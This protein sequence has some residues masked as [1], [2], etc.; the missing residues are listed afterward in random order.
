VQT[1]LLGLA[2]AI[3]VALVTTLVAPLFVDWNRYRVAFED[4]ASRLT[5]VTVRVNGAIDARILPTP[6]INLRDVAV[7]QP[8][9]ES[10]VRAAAVELE[11]GLGPLLQGQI[12]ATELRVVAPQINVGLGRSGAVD[13]PVPSPSPRLETLAISRFS[14]EDARVVLSDAAS[15]ARLVLQKLWF[16]G[17]IRSFAGPFKGEGAFVVGDEL[18]GYHISG[19][20]SD[21]GGGLKLRFGVDPTNHPLTA[22]IEGTL[23]FNQGLPRFDGTL[24]IAR[25]VGATL[26][27]GE[28]VMN[29]PWHLSG[30]LHATPAAASL[31]DLALRYGPEER[32]LDFKGSA[33][34][35]FGARPHIDGTISA[36][37]VDVDRAR[38][39]PEATHRAPFLLIKSFVESFVATVKP[40]LPVAVGVGIGSLIVGGTTIE[41]LDGE[42]RFDDKGW[43]VDGVA[44]RAPG[45]T[46]VNLSG[47][48]DST[49]QGLVFNGPAKLESADAKTLAAWLEGRGNQ[50]PDKVQTLSAN[51]EVTIARNRFAVDRLVAKLERNDVDGRLAY[52]FASD[53]RPAVFDGELRAAAL[54]VDAL[55]SFTKQALM[56]GGLEMPR[57]VTL[58]LD[59]GKATYA[60]VDAQKVNAKL[61]FDSGILHIDRLSVADLDGAGLDVSGQIDDPWSQPRGRITLDLKASALAGL[62]GIVSKFAPAVAGTFRRAVDRLAPAKVHGVLTVDRATAREANAVAAKFNLNGQMGLMRLVLNGEATGNPSHFAESAV[63]VESHLDADD[64]SALTAL[65][66]LD[67]VVAVDQFPGRMSVSAAGPLNGDLQVDGEFTAGGFDSALQGTAHLSGDGAPAGTFQILAAAGDM[68]PLHK[69]ITG[70]PGPAVLVLARAKV[71]VS[72]SGLSFT[73]IAVAVNK[74]SVR[75]RVSIQLSSPLAI[76]GDIAADDADIAGVT[77]MLLGLPS[78]VPGA[79]WS[80]SPVGGGAFGVADGTVAF[81]LGRAT[82]TPT[83]AVLG[84]KGV[85]SL[86]PS[87]ISVTDVDGGL[88]S[89]RLSGTLKVRRDGGALAI[90]GQLDLAGADAAALFG[91]NNI[92]GQATVKLRGDGIGLSP[93]G[94][95]GSLRGDGSVTLNNAHF[96]GI[97]TAAFDAAIRAADVSSAID[98]A[99]IRSAVSAAMGNGHLAVSQ[100]SAEV[101]IGGGQ[102]RLTDATLKAQG[103]ADLTLDGVVDLEKSAIDGR[104]TLKAAPQPNA[105]VTARPEVA[106]TIKGQLA[107]P[108]R[109]V[110]TSTLVSWLALRAAE[111]QT[112]RLESIEA[113]RRDEA[114]G[115]PVRPA[116]PAQRIVPPGTSLDSSLLPAHPSAAGPIDLPPRPRMPPGA[117]DDDRSQAET[118]ARSAAALP[119]PLAITPQAPQPA[120]RIEGPAPNAAAPGRGRPAPPQ[121][122]FP[123]NLFRPQN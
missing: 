15:G 93:E 42:V 21:E 27:R 83:L 31:H 19:N 92:D 69:A 43:S 103:G 101:T 111:L 34:L 33:D 65:L 71:A 54:D 106:V 104:L 16:S 94:L 46:E 3:I 100:G 59:I 117:P 113:N 52:T 121:L 2:M 107:A 20:R 4:E 115:A 47:R 76:N 25:L 28:R 64:G 38:A 82:V 110:E 80:T 122:G 81:T 7:G 97:D 9:A 14:V 23:T 108:E 50:F 32:A 73:D 62:A 51:G 30:V 63:H 90:Q 29:D 99:K 57:D 79:G 24:A 112:R 105:L 41:S 5:G 89:G 68:R 1:T 123:F 44:F 60:G 95:I 10:R 6:R 91:A 61:K 102:I 118:G 66:G 17:D 11:V 18:Y 70:Q 39:A 53:D 87:E 75:G 98:A 40:P 37:Q 35:T 88:A 120:P 96:I 55:I 86:Q 56:D 13:W 114:I 77:A 8:G 45:F 119:A 85:V 74:A 84:L 26:A 48:L 67:R 116:A 78:A 22:D 49:A 12:H 36:S 58:A 109:T 72:G